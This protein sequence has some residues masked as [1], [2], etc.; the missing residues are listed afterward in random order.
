MPPVTIRTKR[1]SVTAD[2]PEAVAARLRK[3]RRALRRDPPGKA[4]GPSEAAGAPSGAVGSPG[5]LTVA[6]TVAELHLERHDPRASVEVFR[7]RMTPSPAHSG[8]EL[9]R[10]VSQISW[11]HT[12]ELPEGVVTEGIY[13]HRALVAH[14]G[15]PESLDGL[16]VLDVASWDG[17]WA[18]ELERRGGQV[19]S[20][21][22]PRLSQFDFPPALREAVLAEGLDRPSTEGFELARQALGSKVERVEGSVYDLDP[23]WL[24]GTFDFVH[25]GD[26]LLHLE[27]PSA[28][29]R[30]IRRVTAGTALIADCFDPSLH[31]YRLTRYYGGWPGAV[32]WWLPSLDVLAQMVLDAGFADVRVHTVYALAPR[33]EREALWRAALVATV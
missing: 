29:L 33:S 21:D 32:L 19:V 7:E 15:I 13:D 18:F 3:A 16:R 17:F 23:S 8:S 22:I 27:T 31:G 20:V 28:A 5:H 14:Y 25:A 9:A 2:L 1:L 26:L 30:A 4:G 10:R 12:I 11:Y 24:G 6:D